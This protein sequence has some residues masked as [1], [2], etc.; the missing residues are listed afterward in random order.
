[1]AKVITFFYFVLFGHT[2]GGIYIL[3]MLGRGLPPLT[4]SSL[5]AIYP[6]SLTHTGLVYNLIFLTGMAMM[7]HATY[8]CRLKQSI[9]CWAS[10]PLRL[11]RSIRIFRCFLFVRIR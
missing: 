11:T 7:A 3:M 9:L 8:S 4:T 2:T 6:A 1:M 10:P 5:N